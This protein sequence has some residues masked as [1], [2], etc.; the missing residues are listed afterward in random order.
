MA[1]LHANAQQFMIMKFI[2]IL[3][4]IYYLLHEKMILCMTED[5]IMNVTCYKICMLMIGRKAS[6]TWYF[7]ETKDYGE[8]MEFFLHFV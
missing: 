6:R 8:A 1:Y 5:I 7:N 4:N 2:L 3:F